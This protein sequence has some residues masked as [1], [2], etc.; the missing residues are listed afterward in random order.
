ML[1]NAKTDMYNIAKP[2]PAFLKNSSC[3]INEYHNDHNYIIL[4][5]LAK[6]FT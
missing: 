3:L 6:L 1:L 4:C 2:S 5:R